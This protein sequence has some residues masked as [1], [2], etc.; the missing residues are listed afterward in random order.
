MV[1]QIAVKRLKVKNFGC[2]QDIDLNLTQL[3]AFIG[4]NDSGK[5][6]LLRAARTAMQLLT[7]KFSGGSDQAL[8]NNG[9]HPFNPGFHEKAEIEVTFIDQLNFVVKFS[10]GQNVRE[11]LIFPNGWL[12]SSNRSLW[13]NSATSFYFGLYRYLTKEAYQNAGLPEDFGPNHPDWAIPMK[14]HRY[15]Q[16]TREI[17]NNHPE[18]QLTKQKPRMVRL[19]PDSLR[20]P[21]GLIPP[22]QPIDLQEKGNGLASIL[23]ALKDSNID[24]YLEIRKNICELFPTV[25]DI[26]VFA[27][28]NSQKAL[29]LKLKNGREISSEF[30]S[31]GMLYYITYSALKYLEPASL[32]LIEEPENGLHPS[33]IK[34]IMK[35]LREVS[36][37]TQV[38][39]ATHSPLVINE[40]QPEEVTVIWRDEDKGTQKMLMKESPNFDE[41]SKVYAL[42]EL[43]LSYADGINE[44][45]LRTGKK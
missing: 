42:G 21:G 29:K 32:L 13:E 11:T 26:N 28:N 7:D 34:D 20:M 39:I 3:H 38:L 23:D 1:N 2:I 12:E 10:I 35:V 41:R 40:M 31:E 25:A 8:I 24:G 5:S 4:P 22:S 15:E 45:N 43:W 17:S 6:T 44:E 16:M 37:T 30:I 33:R 18:I 14:Q 36:K 27:I 19:D 9:C